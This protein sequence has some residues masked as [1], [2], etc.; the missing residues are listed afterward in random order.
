MIVKMVGNSR[1]IIL[2]LLLVVVYPLTAKADILSEGATISDQVD[3]SIKKASSL[4]ER[5][6]AQAQAK[7]AILNNYFLKGRA[8]Y[9]C[10][11][12]NEAIECFE[13]IIDLDP[14]Y[15]PAKLYLE[16]SI[17]QLKIL[18]EK[19]EIN[20]IKLKM[21]DVIA[22]YDKRRNQMDSLAIK[23]F[24]EQAQQ[25]CQLNDFR[26]AE[27]YYNLCYKVYPYS[28]TKIEW[29]VKATYDLIRLSKAL[30]EHGK[31]I[32]ELSVLEE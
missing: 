1:L 6:R 2:I 22:E 21:A 15:E 3:Y 17:I 14:S 20:N 32:E 31:K 30:E 23:Y 16:S 28:K 4:A 27:N 25:K 5:K 8:Y 29:F 9:Q 24:L 10:R 18:K 19:E 7:A 26:G 11:K 13:R 12:Y